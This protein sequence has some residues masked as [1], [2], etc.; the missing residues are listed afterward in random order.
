MLVER[1][2]EAETLY[3]LQ[4]ITLHNQEQ[5]GP[6][7]VVASRLLCLCCGYLPG[8]PGSH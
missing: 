6:F 2:I 3:V 7:S 1:G 4:G 8:G 5:G